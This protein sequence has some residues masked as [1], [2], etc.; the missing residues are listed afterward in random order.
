[1]NF[2]RR[3]KHVAVLLGITVILITLSGVDQETLNN[4][5]L[6]WLLFYVAPIG[7]YI[8]TDPERRSQH[9]SNSN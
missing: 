9:G 4:Y 6:L 7:L 3:E 8:A 1:M 2:T 5:E